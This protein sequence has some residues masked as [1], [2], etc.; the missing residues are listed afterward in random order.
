MKSR[1]HSIVNLKKDKMQKSEQVLSEASTAFR[2]AEEA[3]DLSYKQLSEIEIPS[4]GSI[5]Q[6]LANRELVAA[7]RKLID[8]NKKWVIFA[9][10]QLQDAQEQLKKDMIEH[11]KFKYLESQEIKKEIKKQKEKEAK[12]LDE[13]ALMTFSRGQLS[14]V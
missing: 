1:F 8:D 3:L 12:E 9:R 7:Q 11:E 2:N 4:S 6:L 14:K 13:V 10:K 5:S